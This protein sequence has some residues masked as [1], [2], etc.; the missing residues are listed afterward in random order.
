MHIVDIGTFFGVRPSSDL[1]LSAGTLLQVLEGN[2][3]GEALTCSLKA[4]Q[5]NFSAGNDETLALCQAHDNLY[6]VAVVDPR[7][8]PDCLAE[9]ERCARVGDARFV[10]FRFL[11]EYQGWAI[12]NRGFRRLLQAV[13]LTGKPAIVHVPASG[14]ATA[15]LD[16]VGGWDVPIVL[17]AVS[18]ATLSEALAV[19]AEAPNVYI[20]AHRLTLPGQVEGMVDSVGAERLMF[21]SWAPMFAQRPSMDMVQVSEI[22]DRDKRLI[23]G[24]TA[25]RVFGLPKKE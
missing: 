5:F 15:L 18:Y 14:D 22:G 10:A 4:I 7:Q 12:A 11:R 17:A 9:V 24:E 6:P 1:D 21:G 2:Q 16:A 19:A 25:R 8:Y 23:L 20:E 13:A 3:I